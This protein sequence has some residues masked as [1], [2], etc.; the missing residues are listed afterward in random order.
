[1]ISFKSEALSALAKMADEEPNLDFHT[2]VRCM[3]VIANI[4]E[5]D[6]CITIKNDT[7]VPINPWNPIV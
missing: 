3:A 4:E 6:H 2:I 1:M 7:A 5:E